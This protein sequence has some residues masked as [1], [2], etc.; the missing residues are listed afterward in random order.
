MTELR[1][2]YRFDDFTLDLGERQLRRG[3]ETIDLPN[4]YFDALA[5]M[6]REEGRLVTKDRFMDEVWRGVP[7][8]D[9]ALSQCIKLLRRQLGDSA[10]MPRFIETVPKHGYRFIAQTD[11]ATPATPAAAPDRTAA[12]GL[13]AAGTLGGGIAGMAGGFLYGIGGTYQPLEAGMGAASVLLVL[14]CLSIAV[15]LLGGFGVS[16]GMFAP[17]LIRGG[18]PRPSIVGALAGG[19]VVGGATK[20]LGL[21][22]FNLLFGQAPEGITGG[23]EGAILGGLVALGAYAGSRA[24]GPWWRSIVAA[25][26][27]GAV[28][29]VLVSVAGGRLLGGSLELLAHSFAGSRLRIDAMGTLFGESSFGPV[30]EVAFGGLEGLLFGVGVIGAIVLA[31]REWFAGLPER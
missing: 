30:S 8:T 12:I 29:G 15:G 17:A 21:D 11:T 3:G 25:G 28:A 16:F 13:I 10:A 2:Q 7:V 23:A 9:E 4:R 18:A 22:A 27:A 19:L 6:V 5:L 1:S 14:L 26:I 24:R 31:R 20:L